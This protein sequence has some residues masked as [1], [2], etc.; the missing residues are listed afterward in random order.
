MK[1]TTY[2][3]ILNQE[4][5]R[6]KLINNS[7]SLRALARDLELPAPRLS[8][9]L[10]KKQGLSI[11]SA[12]K[13]AEKL[14]LTK[15]R[16]EWFCNSV[17]ALHSRNQKDRNKYKE[18]I[19]RYKKEA[20][21]F[22]ELHLEYFKVISDWYHF[23]ILELTHVKDFKN[24][25]KWIAETLEISIADVNKAIERMKQLNLLVESD[26]MLIDKFEFLATPSD[27]PS[28]SLK[29]FNTQLMKKAMN[30]LYEQEINNRE[31]SSNIFA[32]D[33][34]K[35]TEF[36][37]YIR[38]FRREIDQKASKHENKNSVYCLSIEMFE[39]TRSK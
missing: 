28:D 22:S 32:F 19:K 39:L 7:Y 37:T 35:L 34:N 12:S 13:I 3:D 10:A 18:R 21:K 14:K 25:P 8:L 29:K 4:F 5:E 20:Q 27:T 23:A 24:E 1:H 31:I 36:K 11:E 6:R 9:I 33:K 26:G 38:K 2:Q 15:E 16:K 17:G 30:A